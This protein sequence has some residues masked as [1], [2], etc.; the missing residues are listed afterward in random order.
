MG[1]LLSLRQT[2]CMGE[3]DFEGPVVE[4]RGPAPFFFVRLP[5]DVSAEIKSA[6][7]GMEYWGQ[8]AVTVDAAGVAFSTALFPKDG[9]YLL[10]LKAAV[11]DRLGV[12]PGDDVAGS[13]GLRPHHVAR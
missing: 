8:V 9:A 7:A 10:P 1:N 12:V 2:P 13:L 11:R 5:A 4:W 6:V 3:F